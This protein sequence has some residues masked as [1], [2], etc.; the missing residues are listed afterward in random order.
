MLRYQT[1]YLFLLMSYLTVELRKYFFNNEKKNL[2]FCL[3]NMY[4]YLPLNVSNAIT[5]HI[6]TE[7]DVQR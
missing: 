7:K 1:K 4:K 2:H 3:V 5:V 6:T